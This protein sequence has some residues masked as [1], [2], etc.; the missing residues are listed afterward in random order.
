MLIPDN[1]FVNLQGCYIV[2]ILLSVL[3]R[4]EYLRIKNWQSVPSSLNVAM[5]MLLHYSVSTQHFRAS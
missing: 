2:S 4:Q 5:Y 3:F 1:L